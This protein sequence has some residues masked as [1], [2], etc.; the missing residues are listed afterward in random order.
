MRKQNI[1]KGA[2]SWQISKTRLVAFSN[3][4]LETE[5]DEQA[6]VPPP[7]ESTIGKGQNRKPS[8]PQERRE[9]PPQGENEQD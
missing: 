4:P 5:Q 7:G 6:K 2:R 8:S 3:A 1:E 9:P